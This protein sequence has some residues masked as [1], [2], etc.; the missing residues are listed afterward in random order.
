MQLDQTE[1]LIGRL[2]ELHKGIRDSIMRRR[3]EVPMEQLVQVVQ[4]TES[5]VKFDIDAAAE[6]QVV[7]FCRTWAAESK[8]CFV[9]VAEGVSRA[10]GEPE[11]VIFPDGADERDARFILIVDPCDGSRELMYDKRSAWVLSGI[12]PCKPEGCTLADIAVAVQTELPITKQTLADTLH[13]ATGTRTSC[14]R[15]DLTSGK[16]VSRFCPVPSAARTIEQGFATISKFFPGG[17][18][19][20]ARIEESLAHRLM[21]PIRKGQAAIFDDQYIS[22]GGQL[23]ELMIGHDRF[24]ADIRPLTAGWLARRGLGMLGLCA[25]PYDLCTELVARQAGVHVCQPDGRPLAAQLNTTTEVAWVGY[26]N[27]SLRDQIEP[28]FQE[29]LAHSLLHPGTPEEPT[30]RRP[31]MGLPERND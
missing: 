23:Y 16:I 15:H 22:T 9:L 27:Q 21:G 26:A 17:K 30:E 8:I 29:L 20:A 7:D 2:K 31:A 19:L 1:H 25:H 11:R 4:S 6:E 13:A 18:E 3:R 12:A 14:Q 5:D 28:H 24:I 10:P